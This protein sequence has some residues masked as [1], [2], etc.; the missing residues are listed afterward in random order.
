MEASMKTMLVRKN[1]IWLLIAIILVI[2][3]I[4]CANKNTNQTL[5]CMVSEIEKSTYDLNT[6][7]ISYADYKKSTDKYLS[8]YFP[9]FYIQGNIIYTNNGLVKV[10]TGKDYTEK[11][12][13]GMSF[14]EI[15]KIGEPLSQSIAV[16]VLSYN[17]KSC[18]I[19]KVYEDTKS[20]SSLQMKSVFVRRDI[21]MIDGTNAP[22][23][24]KYTFIKDGK[25]Y[26]LLSFE[27]ASVS[28]GQE[29]THG[30]EKVDFVQNINLQ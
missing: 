16:N 15:K 24:K 28:K 23:Y 25:S 10:I 12:W 14:E 6:V 19:S 17:Y 26:V 5:L 7:K 20:G 1:L 3:A 8:K 22:L 30:N 18:G 29:L 13:L 21:Q 27:N 11:D 9:S 4:G 2:G